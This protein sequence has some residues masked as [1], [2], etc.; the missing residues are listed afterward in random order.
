MDQRQLV[1]RHRQGALHI[2]I[3]I[4]FL[5][6]LVITGSTRALFVHFVRPSS[7]TSRP[8]ALPIADAKQIISF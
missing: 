5:P 4:L 8:D 3:D 7:S 1:V 2:D 6:K